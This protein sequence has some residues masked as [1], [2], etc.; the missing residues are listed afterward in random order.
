MQIVTRDIINEIKNGSQ[1]A[2][3]K[4]VEEQRQY[5]YNLAFRILCDEE[6]AKDSVQESF[7]KIWRKIGEYDTRMKLTTWMYRIVT[8][9]AIDRFRSIRRAN[10]MKI[11]DLGDKLQQMQ[12]DSMELILD[13]KELGQIIRLLADK[14]P[15]KQRLV[16]AMRDLQEMSSEEV[17]AIL[18]IDETQ[19][20][21]NLY[22]A[23]KAVKE[24]L[25]YI[26]NGERKNK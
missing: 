19:V 21:S 5:A 4:L 6:E 20:K 24:K 2:F 15:E 3:R 1:E 9:T 26:L 7:I 11:D 16:F 25:N 10:T 18:E 17:E 22:H 12:E 13:N 23:R 14:L 8:N